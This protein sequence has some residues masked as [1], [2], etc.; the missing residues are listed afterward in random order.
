MTAKP[1]S[2]SK[3]NPQ[4]EQKSQP[5]NKFVAVKTIDKR[6][7][8]PRNCKRSHTNAYEQAISPLYGICPES[9]RN[10]R[11]KPD[12]LMEMFPLPEHLK[13]LLWLDVDLITH[14]SPLETA[15]FMNWLLDGVDRA[16][17]RMK[18]KNM[19]STAASLIAC[20]TGQK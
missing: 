11:K 14:L 20:F 3:Q 10:Y 8:E 7:F 19:P 2:K 4:K 18:M 16:V 13:L 5:E 12:E 1:K 15:K 17:E 6:F 9:C